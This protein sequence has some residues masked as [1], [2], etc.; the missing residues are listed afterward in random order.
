MIHFSY[1]Q[2]KAPDNDVFFFMQEGS[3]TDTSMAE[4]RKGVSMVQSKK[5]SQKG[6]LKQSL[7]GGSKLRVR[8]RRNVC[9]V[10]EITDYRY[11][12]KLVINWINY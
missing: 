5:E 6:I 12:W 9:I 2:I 1:A 4:E 8:S 7:Y 3:S 11:V 10:E